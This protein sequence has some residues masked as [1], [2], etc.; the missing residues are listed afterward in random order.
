MSKFTKVLLPVLLL[1]LSACNNANENINEN[2]IEENLNSSETQNAYKI[3]LPNID[4]IEF[5]VSNPKP[6]ALELVKLYV[7][8]LNPDTQRINSVELNNVEL[9]GLTSENNLVVYE[10]QM[11]A[12][13]DATITAE[14]VEVYAVN[15]DSEIQNRFT[16]TG[17]DQTYAEGEVVTFMPAAHPGFWFKSIAAVEEDVVLTKNDNGSYSF[18]MPAHAVTIT[19]VTGENVYAVTAE[20]TDYY[21]F[22]GVN[23]NQTFSIGEEVKFRVNALGYDTVITGVFV[24]GV[25]LVADADGYY[26]F[27]MPTYG[28]T[29]TATYDIVYRTVV[30]VD[31]EHFTLSLTTVVNEEEVAAGNNVLA[32]QVVY[33]EATEKPTETPHNF[34]VSG[35]IFEAGEDAD[36][37]YTRSITVRTDA[38]GREYFTVPTSYKYIKVSIEEVESEFKY[39]PLVGTYNGYRPY[40]GGN[41]EASLDVLGE[42]KLGSSSKGTL[43]KVSDNHYTS[44]N[45]YSTIN[46]FIDLETNSILYVEGNSNGGSYLFTKTENEIDFDSSA[47]TKVYSYYVTESSSL[48]EQFYYVTYTD[49]TVVTCH[50]NYQTGVVT[51]GATTTLISGTDGKTVG[52]VVAVLDTEGNEISRYEVLDESRSGDGWQMKSNIVQA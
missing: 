30:G 40:Y 49:G 20:D 15:V 21:R 18:V 10:F 13:A 22:N 25:E 46:Y 36:N 50:Y 32:E 16:L 19:A 41:Y 2:S 51:F 29:L 14:V 45:G 3:V 34:I 35:F 5:E 48:I 26:S 23:N 11:P 12:N 42:F 33:V 28:V 39:S 52:D 43:T 31:S 37:L 44:S 17:I 8:N 9:L 27:L 38:E 1:T 6:Q 24:D 47:A 4:G 7:R